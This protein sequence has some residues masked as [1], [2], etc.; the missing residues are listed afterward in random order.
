[1]FQ[2]REIHPFQLF[3]TRSFGD[4]F[5]ESLERPAASPPSTRS[6]ESSFQWTLSGL[7]EG[8]YQSPW[9][10]TFLC[11]EKQPYVTNFPTLQAWWGF[12]RFSVDC[13]ERI[14]ESKGGREI[15]VAV[16]CSDG[17]REYWSWSWNKFPNLIHFYSFSLFESVFPWVWE[18]RG[19][20]IYLVLEFYENFYIPFSWSFKK[21]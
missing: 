5:N 21:Y 10:A 14:R 1:M 8:W 17:E 11:Y 13:C 19:L 15:L 2:Q 7:F 4:R 16:G 12:E 6:S 3:P 9:K 18:K 20:W